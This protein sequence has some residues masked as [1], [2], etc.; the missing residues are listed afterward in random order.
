ML[1]NTNKN[2]FGL[3]FLGKF[4]C[5]YIQIPFL[6]ERKKEYI[7]ICQNWANMNM[8]TILLIVIC[9]CI[10]EYKYYINIYFLIICLWL[11]NTNTNIH[12]TL[13][14]QYKDRI[15]KKFFVLHNIKR[16]KEMDCQLFNT[17]LRTEN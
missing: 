4:Q 12:Q 9:K 14:F 7:W 6:D 10:Y 8:N 5:K 15:P 11:T 3:T 17:K 2:M 16:T 13:Y 1:A